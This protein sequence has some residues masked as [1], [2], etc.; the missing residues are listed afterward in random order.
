MNDYKE[1]E[2]IIANL[3]SYNYY[4]KEKKII[5]STL[6]IMVSILFVVF[7]MMDNLKNHGLTDIW[8]LLLLT[9]TILP[10]LGFMLIYKLISMKK[11]YNKI[12]KYYPNRIVVTKEEF[13]SLYMDLELEKEIKKFVEQS[14]PMKK[15]LDVTN[16][17]ID[18]DML[19]IQYIFD[20][21]PYTLNTVNYIKCYDNGNRR[22][23]ALIIEKDIIFGLLKGD[24]Y[25]I[26]LYNY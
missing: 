18:G 14:K 6:L 8:F 3:F 9:I 2:Q 24:L 19:T 16:I 22:V 13:K 5:I 12:I 10:Y 11:N 20:N 25:H 17:Q 15:I 23:E 1:I 4:K 26:T 21:Q 7:I